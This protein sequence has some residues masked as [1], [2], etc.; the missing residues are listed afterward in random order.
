[1][2]VLGII[3]ARYE[4]SRIAHKPLFKLLGIECV[5]H[6]YYR[7]VL[8]KDLTDLI[9]ATD[10]EIIGTFLGNNNI[11]YLITSRTHNNPTERMIEVIKKFPN[12]ERYVLVNGDEVLLNP[13]HIKKSIELLHDGKYMVSLLLTNFSKRNSN[14]DFKVV[15]NFRNEVIYISRADIPSSKDYQ[16]SKFLKAYHLMTFLPEALHAYSCF[17]PSELEII[18]QHEHIRFIENGYKIITDI[19]DSNSIS[20]DNLDDVSYIENQLLSDPLFL[21][22]SE[23]H[24]NA[25][26]GK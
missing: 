22:Y 18:E 10:S 20:L 1:M 25:Q 17:P 16:N 23:Q 2:K 6:V 12:Y 11:P 3:P 14:S 21:N 26:S 7:A 9:V 8:S 15:R 19:V 5:L 4:S 13:Q 24:H